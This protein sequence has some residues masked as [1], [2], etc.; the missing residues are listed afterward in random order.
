MK[1]SLSDISHEANFDLLACDPQG[2][3]LLRPVTPRSHTACSN[4]VPSAFLRVL[5]P[6]I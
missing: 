4:H 6:S 1:K 2:Q 5:V 3:L